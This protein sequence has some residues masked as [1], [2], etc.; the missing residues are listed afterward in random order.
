MILSVEARAALQTSGPMVMFGTKWPSI[1]STWIQSAP[2]SATRSGASS[3]DASVGSFSWG[4]IFNT[5]FWVDP[6]EQ[7]IGVL[8]TQNIVDPKLNTGYE[9]FVFKEIRKGYHPI[10][11]VWSALPTIAGTT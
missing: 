1:T 8:M 10:E 5:Y 2:A 4:G 7:L 9:L 11:P 6:Q 3:D